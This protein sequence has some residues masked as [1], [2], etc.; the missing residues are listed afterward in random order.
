M[1]LVCVWLFVC[2]QVIVQNY[3]SVLTLSR[4]YQSSDAL[5]VHE[6]DVIHKICAQLMNIKQISFR[7]VN[8]VIAHQLGSVFQPAHTAGGGSGYSRNPLGTKPNTH[9][10]FWS[11]LIS[12]LKFFNS[13]ILLAQ[14]SGYIPSF[15][16]G[17]YPFRSSIPTLEQSQKWLP[18]ILVSFFT[19][20]TLFLFFTDTLV[21]VHISEESCAGQ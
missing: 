18:S 8:Q 6:N 14:V 20:R 12:E 21:P 5:L 1:T 2:F 7:D 15:K 19:K 16:T 11:Q 10:P 3:N 4:L 17:K 9:T 13:E